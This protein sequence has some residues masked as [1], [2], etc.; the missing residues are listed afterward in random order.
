CLDQPG[1]DRPD[2]VAV[3]APGELPEHAAAL[4]AHSNGAGFFL[5]TLGKKTGNRRLPEMLERFLQLVNRFSR[6]IHRSLAA[7]RGIK[8]HDVFYRHNKESAR[9]AM[10]RER[11]SGL[12]PLGWRAP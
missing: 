12:C 6:E 1:C 7:A 8:I 9:A 5:H 2:L 3:I 4:V 10:A 11:L